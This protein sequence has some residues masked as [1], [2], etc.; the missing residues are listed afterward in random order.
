MTKIYSTA[1]QACAAATRT[2]AAPLGWDP[3]SHLLSRFSFGATPLDRTSSLPNNLDAWWADE[4]TK[5]S[6]GPSYNIVPTVGALG[7]LLTQSPAQVRAWLASQ[8]NQYGFTALEQLTQVTLGLQIWS[9]AQLFETLVDFF[10]NHLNIANNQGDTWITRHVYDRDVIRPHAAG[11]FEDML[12]ASAKDAAMLTFLNG[13]QSTKSAVNENYGRELLELHTV[14]L[15]YTESDV[16][17]SAYILTGRCID[18]TTYQYVYKPNVHYVG[19]VTVLGFSSPNNSATGGEAVGD[20]YLRYLAHHQLTAN[21]IARKLCIRFVSDNPSAS[22][23]NQVAATYLAND[24]EILPTVHAILCSDEFW[25]SR[26]RKVRRPAENA[27]ASYRILGVQPST[28]FIEN[29]NDLHWTLTGVNNAPLDYIPPTGYPEVASA[30]R[31]AG[32][33]V[34][35]WTI[36]RVLVGNWWKGLTTFDPTSLFGGAAPTTAGAA[37]DVI[38]RRITGSTL[39]AADRATLLSVTGDAD[40]TPFSKS[41]I[42]NTWRLEGVIALILDSPYHALR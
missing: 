40:G 29:M 6:A 14:G 27:I 36:H 33:L 17:N 38:S 32:G 7:P 4:V 9:P 30:W 20:D 22:L 1:A 18:S 19:P 26:G 37:L 10:S 39:A 21:T 5:A 11:R 13:A 35:A 28:D 16:R 31:S 3:A 12:L 23:I 8:G 41:Q 42:S 24:T 34:T 25:A 15:N 2:A